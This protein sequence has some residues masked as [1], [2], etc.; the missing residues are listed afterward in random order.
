[1]YTSVGTASTADF[2]FLS[3]IERG[4]IYYELP[5]LVELLGSALGSAL[6]EYD[7]NLFAVATDGTQYAC[8]ASSG[9]SLCQIDYSL[10]YTPQ[11][12]NIYPSTVYPGQDICVEV[13]SDRAT[14]VDAPYNTTGSIG[15]YVIDFTEYADDNNGWDNT[16]TTYQLCGTAG[17]NEATDSSELTIKSWVGDYLVTDFAKSYDG[18]SAFEVRSVPSVDSISHS[19]LYNAPGSIITIIGD[20][21]SSTMAS[22]EVTVDD[23]SCTILSSS[24]TEI[25]CQLPEKTTTTTGTEFVGGTGAREY[26]Y[27]NLYIS[28]L[29]TDSVANSTS[30]FTDITSRRNVEPD[31]RYTRT[32][33]YWFIPPQTAN[34]TFH[35]SCDDYCSAYISTTPDDSSSLTQ[36]LSVYWN[37]WRNFWNPS[38]DS[39][40]SDTPVALTA[41]QHYYMKVYHQDSGYGEYVTVG[42]TTDDVSVSR[43]NSQS[44]WKKLTIDGNQTFEEYQIDIPYTSNASYR[45][46]FDTCATYGS[47][48]AFGCST[49]TCPCVSSTFTKDSSSNS[50][51]SAVRTYFDSVRGSYGY[52]MLA[53][54]KTLDSSGAETSDTSLIET[55]RFTLTGRLTISS[56]PETVRIYSNDGSTTATIAKNANSTT[57]LE[58]RFRIKYNDGTS[59][60]YTSD[61]PLSYHD[62]V[63]TREFLKTSP[64]LLGKIEFRKDF[65]T[66]VSNTEG[67]DLYYRTSVA[68]ANALEITDAN[69]TS[70][71]ISGGNG[72]TFTSTTHISASNNPFYPSIPGTMVRTYEDKP[73]VIVKSNGLTAACII[74]G[75]CDVEFVANVGEI[76]NW[77]IDAYNSFITFTGTSL[78]FS[79]LTFVDIGS[80]RKCEIDDSL[81]PSATTFGCNI[82]SLIAGTHTLYTQTSS[83]AIANAN[84]LATLDIDIQVDTV[85]PTTVYSSGGQTMTITGDYFPSSLEEA[86]SITDFAVTFTGGNACTVTSVTQYVIK[87]VS[88]SGLTGSPQITVS[89]NGKSTTYA[90]ALTLSTVTESVTSVDK[91]SVCPVEKQDLVITVSDTPSTNIAY[92]T[93]IIIS[94]N[95]E[96]L[97]RINAVDTTT[98]QLTARFPGAP[99]FAEY[100]V[101]VEYND[102]SGAKRYNSNVVISTNSTITGISITTDNSGKTNVSTSGGDIVEITGTAFSTDA[103]D[104]IVIFGSAKAE[105]I[106]AAS[107]LLTVRAPVHNS[108][109]SVA[110]SVFLLPNLEAI[111]DIAA[112]CTVTYDSSQQPTLSSSNPH[113]ITSGQVTIQGSGFGSNAVAYIDGYAQSTVSSSTSEVV[114][115]LS[116]FNDP[117]NLDIVVQTDSVNLPSITLGDITP[118]IASVST[119]SGSEGGQLL[120]FEVV[121][122]GLS[123]TSDLVV[124]YNTS[125]VNYEFCDTV[126]LVDSSTVTCMT[127]KDLSMTNAILSMQY[128]YSNTTDGT[129]RRI[130][131]WCEPLSNCY[132]STA[133]GSTPNLDTISVDLTAGQIIGTVDFDWIGSNAATDYTATVYY[134]SLASD[135]ATIDSTTGTVTGVFTN[136]IFSSVADVR[137]KFELNSEEIY[138][139][140]V[141]DNGS[142]SVTVTTVN[143]C[144]WA[145]GCEFQVQGTNI[146]TVGSSGDINVT[147]CG[148]PAE[149]YSLGTDS[150]TVR[151]PV[152]A[153][154]HSLASYDVEVSTNIAS[155]ATITSLPADEGLK[156]F[157]SSTTTKFVS[158]N[159]SNCYVQ[160]SFEAGKVGRLE[161]VR[162][163][164]AK[165]LDKTTNYVGKLKFQNS[166]DQTTWG[167]VWTA[168]VY[169]SEGWNNIDLSSASSH[170]QYYRF[171]AENKE[172]CQIAEIELI[173]NVVED[174]SSTTKSCTVAVETLGTA[175]QETANAITYDDSASVV[176]SSVSPRYVSY[177]GGDVLTITGTGFTTTTADISVTIDG[178]TCTVT[179]ATSTQ[180]QCSA[181]ARP[182][183]VEEGVTLLH[184]GGASPN[185]YAAMHNF[186]VNYANYWSDIETWGGEY[187]PKE[188]DSIVIPK[189]QTLIV[190]IDE[191][192]IINAIIVY[193][194]LVFLP[195]TDSSHVRTFDARYIFVHEG[196]VFEVGTED[197]RYTSYITITMHGTREDPQIPDYGNKGIFVRRGQ[198]DIHGAVR[199]YTWAEL[200]V[201]APAGSTSIT[202]NTTVDWKA[203]EVIVIAPTDYEVDH[204]E[205]FT[206]NSTSTTNGK[207]TLKLKGTTQYL[208]FAGSK[209]YTGTNDNGSKTKTLEMRAEV[210]LL[211]RNVKYKGADDDSVAQQYGAHIMM[212]SS[213]DESL[214]G[215]ISYSEFTQVG[216]AFQLGRYPIHFHMIGTVHNSYVKGNAIHHTYN[217]ACTIHGVHYLTIE[218]NVAFETMGHTYFIEDGAET[219][220]ILKDNL[221]VKSKRS[222]SLLNTDQ[223]PASFWIT[224]PDNTFIGNHA[225][226]SDRYGFWFDLQ[227]H[228]TGPSFDASICPEFSQL[229]EFTGNVA[230]SNGRY[231]L[232]F[233]HRF[234]PSDDPCAALATGAHSNREQPDPTKITPIVTHI[235][236]F[237]GYKNKRTALIG[238]EIGALKFHNIR[239][240]DNILSDVE[241]SNTMAGPWLNSSDDYHLQDA[242]LVGCSDN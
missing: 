75:A 77:S 156:A 160:A 96:I 166:S 206:I 213:G 174:T 131:M 203:D 104:H 56:G 43:P 72:V 143:S 57:P 242:L 1:M 129:S 125:A 145:G 219:K 223:T 201:T 37:N 18:T 100:Y 122:L 6:S 184:F 142:T 45:V 114:V 92:Y 237:L 71:A 59:T 16:Y 111:C 64:E 5:S 88:P 32:L 120:T 109:E 86:N 13:F 207:T 21:F 81:T 103:S 241:F 118:Y 136:G 150:I 62:G 116:K 165:M 14:S 40:S 230:H 2:G 119:L 93:G 167:D 48:T 180:I 155:M 101:Y 225:A 19:T 50:V 82:Y 123:T 134:G 215:R 175:T 240:A 87:C 158:T 25:K 224:H 85:V 198:L 220:N 53:D 69:D 192:P 78:P 97:M 102:G 29:T 107:T 68:L 227:I 58:G 65:K 89:F 211:T 113:N 94:A 209:D 91:T 63:V 161:K 204:A 191:S 234:T 205:Q 23:L 163:F 177:L 52:H 208:H 188:G 171:F 187:L 47:S 61:I 157:D 42:F 232:R 8:P 67:I 41:G 141:T 133:A 147:V 73:Q 182:T 222:W 189:G 17:G 148:L 36:V 218:K 30:L 200:D 55:V 108:D 54:K 236:D 194:A 149:I 216:Q 106:S 105:I 170:Y 210:G 83:G 239:A 126:T 110:V 233:F 31:E 231:G 196:A 74:E 140:K 35:A 169:L 197:N 46:A 137:I 3:N 124:Y 173:G 178:I 24:S 159:D 221:A 186:Q 117:E 164:M 11:I 38:P 20:G 70:N 139:T 90:T 132:Y 121:G 39:I 28:E 181:G 172:A 15:D 179:S 168:D 151:A 99:D 95:T 49:I 130:I 146:E 162:F 128:T 183:V 212:H 235:R 226:G 185:G 12:F 195:D 176:V 27:E 80:Q 34:Y 228:P 7:P 84:G 33:E 79:D 44:E 152:Y 193:G 238:T 10:L 127:K 144:S 9:S 199:D 4:W 98:K 135:S 190:D 138:S 51:K 76:T 26:I 202:L 115:K 60:R 217:R 154:T 229:G 22:N 153:T 112:G 214:T 66:F